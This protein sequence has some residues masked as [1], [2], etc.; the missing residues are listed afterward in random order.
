MAYKFHQADTLFDLS[1]H[2][3]VASQLG[4]ARSPPDP[5]HRRARISTSSLLG[6]NA[7]LHRVC[8]VTGASDI[9]SIIVPSRPRSQTKDKIL[10]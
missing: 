1:L 9:T 3:K 10:V 8:I 6:W 7:T 2:V 5:V 4:R